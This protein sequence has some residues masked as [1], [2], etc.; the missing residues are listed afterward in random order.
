[1]RWNRKNDKYFQK[2]FE[3]YD[4]VFKTRLCSLDT[5]FTCE[6]TGIINPALE[7]IKKPWFEYFS[8]I[9]NIFIA[10]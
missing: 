9:F 7:H 5:T 3:L 4:H 10:K 1:M 2:Y 8:H 6:D